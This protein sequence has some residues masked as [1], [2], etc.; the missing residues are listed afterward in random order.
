MKLTLIGCSYSFFVGL[1]SS[2]IVANSK[3]LASGAK[4]TGLSAA[5][6]GRNSTAFGGGAALATEVL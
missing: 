4:G 5:V 3:G 6:A 2:N 1:A